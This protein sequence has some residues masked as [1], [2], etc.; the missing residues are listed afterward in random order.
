MELKPGGLP[1]CWASEI[2]RSNVWMGYE[3]T[4]LQQY[5]TFDGGILISNSMPKYLRPRY[6]MLSPSERCSQLAQFCEQLLNVCSRQ[7]PGLRTQVIVISNRDIGIVEGSFLSRCFPVILGIKSAA[8]LLLLGN[9][10]PIQRV[11][12]Q[13]SALLPTLR[14]LFSSRALRPST[15]TSAMHTNRNSSTSA[16]TGLHS[17]CTN[18]G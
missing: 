14:P 7:L 3:P 18:V 12:G 6:S 17:Y 15:T 8:V 1:S 11:P 16:V 5:S 2:T 10:R 9:S 13:T 4:P